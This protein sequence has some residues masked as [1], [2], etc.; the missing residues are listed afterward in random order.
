[1]NAKKN[2]P[3][4]PMEIAQGIREML[5]QEKLAVCTLPNRRAMDLVIEHLSYAERCRTRFQFHK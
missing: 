2:E 5:A 4:T 3:Q 1:M